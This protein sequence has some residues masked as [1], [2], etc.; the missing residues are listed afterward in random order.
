MKLKKLFAVLAAVA[1]TASMS[2]TSYAADAVE[3]AQGGTK[4]A[5]DQV[6]SERLASDTTADVT[7]SW[8]PGKI[9]FDFNVVD[10]DIDNTAS[11]EY[12]RDSIE[13]RIDSM[14][15]IRVAA[16]TGEAQGG[17]AGDYDVAWALT[18]NGYNVKLTYSNDAVAEGYEFTFAGQVNCA[19]GGSRQCTLHVDAAQENAWQDDTVRTP[20]ILLG[21]AAVADDVAATEDETA[22]DT[23]ADDVVV[24]D[25]ATDDAVEATATNDTATTAAATTTTAAAGNTAAATTASKG[26]ADTGI[27]GVAVV[28]GLAVIGTGAVVISRKKK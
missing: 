2:L 7:I 28:I 16:A 10:S 12:A 21:G 20:A 11:A 3:I 6:S 8:E 27:E 19:S 17:A 13:L 4:L 14:S 1:V 9:M 26:S 23:G 18:D 25:V 24:E 22:E 5:L 15:E